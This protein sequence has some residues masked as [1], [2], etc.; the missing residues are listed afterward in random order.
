VKYSTQL[1]PELIK[2]AKLYAISSDVKDYEVIRA[3]LED[4]KAKK[5]QE[6]PQA[7]QLFDLI[8]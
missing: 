2:W 4:F 8:A 5:E 1:P 3:A 7:I 6:T